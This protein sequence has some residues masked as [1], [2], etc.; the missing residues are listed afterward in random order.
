MLQK[1]GAVRCQGRTKVGERCSITSSTKLVDKFNGCLLA[2]PLRKGCKFCW[3]HM[4]YFQTTLRAIHPI[5]KSGNRATCDPLLFFFD[6]ETTGLSIKDDHIVEIGMFEASTGAKFC[7]IVQPTDV[8]RSD[9][10]H[11]IEHS[12]L[13]H[14]PDFRVAFERMSAFIG[15]L[16]DAAICEDS[17]SSDEADAALPRIRDERAQVLVLAH[18]GALFD[19]PMLISECW[20]HDARWDHLEQWLFVD[21][22]EVLRALG[23]ESLSGCLK[24]QC[25]TRVCSRLGNLQAHRALDDAI[26]LHAVLE[27]LSHRLDVAMCELA[28]HFARALDVSA[29]ATAMGVLH[30]SNSQNNVR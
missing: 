16:A 13:A 24:L 18:N 17:D 6:L 4:K 20:R 27:H 19:F 28:G 21:T 23:P 14:G 25:L 15:N 9:C 26:A 11:G 29:T 22:L 30:D 1:L 2:D 10:I 7:T 8:M 5:A 3:L 12:E